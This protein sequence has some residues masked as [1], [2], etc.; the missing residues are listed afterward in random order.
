MQNDALLNKIPR[1]DAIRKHAERYP[2]ID[3][4]AVE[5]FLTTVHFAQELL[6]ATGGYLER[7]NLSPGRFM[8]M[9][10]LNK[11]PGRGVSPSEIAE[12]A[13]V[14]RATVTGLV[15]GL[16]RDGFVDR[17]PDPKDRR[18]M[19]LRLTPKA[20][21][22]LKDMLPGH[23]RRIARLMSCLTE[24]ERTRLRT[25]LMKIHGCLDAFTAEEAPSL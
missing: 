10:L 9:M 16:A 17:E 2:D 11:E 7:M 22:F 8:V 13:G 12:C 3:P 14:T 4:T 18:A 15:D 21:A 1:L 25:L 5:S 6:H 23:Y 24:S 20:Q 19:L